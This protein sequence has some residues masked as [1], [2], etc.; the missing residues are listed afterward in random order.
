LQNGENKNGA[1]RSAPFRI[2]A[3]GFDLAAALLAP[4]EEGEAFEQLHVGFVLQ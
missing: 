4:G 1:D 3:C 2:R